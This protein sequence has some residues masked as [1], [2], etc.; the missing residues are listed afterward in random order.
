MCTRKNKNSHNTGNRTKKMHVTCLVVPST[1]SIK[2]GQGH[3]FMLTK[4]MQIES[5]QRV[6]LHHRFIFELYLENLTVQWPIFYN[7][8][9]PL[10]CGGCIPASCLV[11]AWTAFSNPVILIRTEHLLNASF[12]NVQIMF[13]AFLNHFAGAH[14]LHIHLYCASTLV[15][16]RAHFHQL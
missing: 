16:T 1:V 13:L 6:C 5:I 14:Y 4:R 11:T 2:Q 7:K 10:A 3:I 15:R 12:F 9:C 8:C